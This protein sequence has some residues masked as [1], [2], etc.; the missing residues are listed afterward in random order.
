MNEKRSRAHHRRGKA[1]GLRHDPKKGFPSRSV[2]LEQVM[3][4]TDDDRYLVPFLTAEPGS[5]E[6]M[7]ATGRLL[8]VAKKAFPL[9]TPLAVWVTTDRVETADYDLKWRSDLEPNPESL[10]AELSF[11]R[12]L[13]GVHRGGEWCC[14]YRE[15]EALRNDIVDRC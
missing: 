6:I 3:R 13:A 7:V 2:L 5:A 15:L 8:A 9:R 12:E 11:L 4:M 1:N 14:P 10:W